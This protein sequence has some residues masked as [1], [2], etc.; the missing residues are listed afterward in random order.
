MLR[1]VRVLFAIL[2]LI[3]VSV[4]AFAKA[5]FGAEF[6]FSNDDI[7]AAQK[8]G[9]TVVNPA[10]KEYRDLMAEKVKASCPQCKI[11]NRVNAF[12][13]LIYRITYPDGWYFFIATDPGV[14]EVQTKPSTVEEIKS[15]LATIQ[16]DIFENAREAGLLP[17]T[18]VNGPS[19]AGSHIHIGVQ[20]ALGSGQE[21]T[22]KLRNFMADF[23][24]HSELAEGVFTLDYLNAPALRR[25]PEKQLGN[26][27]R[28]VEDV[29]SGRIKTVVEFARRVR[30]EVYDVTSYAWATP[31]TKYQAFNLDRIGNSKFEEA[32]QTFEIRA[33]RGQ[34]SAQE[35]LDQIRL[36]DSR[37]DHLTRSGKP[38]TLA[39][40]ELNLRSDQKAEQFHAYV[41][42][43]GLS[44]GPYRK[45]L[46][47][48]QRE[49]LRT[50]L[51]ASALGFR[52]R[53]IF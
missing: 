50:T 38:V 48:T 23:S 12:G 4:E 3:A 32:H 36:L 43:S 40:S 37:L 27:E 39:L 53:A 28:I 20:S 25:L 16:K 26:F 47:P 5:T 24:N 49:H 45:Y 7:Q 42:E 46:T 11:E 52:C 17:A 9:T 51:G 41:T 21:A 30:T 18:Q 15:R 35:F 10:S 19:W 33:M 34:E 8:D 14:I 13:T 6:N 31:T 2:I 22:K 1:V 29:D 44:F